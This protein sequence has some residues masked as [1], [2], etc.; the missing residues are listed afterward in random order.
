MEGGKN[1]A[2]GGDRHPDVSPFLQG[3]DTSC[4]DVRVRELGSVRRDD[5]GD[6]DHMNGVSKADTW[7]ARKSSGRQDLGDTGGIG[8]P[9]GGGDAVVGQVNWLLAGDGGAVGVLVPNP[10]DLCKGKRLLEMRLE[11]KVVV[12]EVNDQG[13]NVK[14]VGGVSMGGATKRAGR[15]RVSR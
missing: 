13:E 3:G 8:G 15:V 4:P 11:V 1:V 14:Y 12:E 6:G 9:T 2:T 5:T 10:E 7:E